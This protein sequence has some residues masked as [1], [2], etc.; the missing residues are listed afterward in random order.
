[1]SCER[2]VMGC[3]T[4]IAA[5]LLSFSA[6][7]AADF[8]WTGGAGNNLY[9]DKKN[10]SITNGSSTRD[11]PSWTEN[12]YIDT[13]L[14]GHD[15]TIILNTSDCCADILETRGAYK[16]TFVSDANNYTLKPYRLNLKA[17]DNEF[18]VP[19]SLYA[20]SDRTWP[21]YANATFNKDVTLPD[22]M[23]IDNATTSGNLKNAVHFYGKL[24]VKSGKVLGLCRAPFTNYAEV[25]FHGPLI[26]DEL[27]FGLG[28]KSGYAYFY[29]QDNQIGKL[30]WCYSKFICCD[31]NVYPS[32]LAVSWPSS[33]V[34]PATNPKVDQF[35]WEASPSYNAL[36]LNGHDQKA[37]MVS[38][39][40]ATR[41]PWITSESPAVLTLDGSG[42]AVATVNIGGKA[43][44]VVDSPDLVQEFMNSQSTTLGTLAVNQGVLRITGESLFSAVPEVSVGSGATFE[45]ASTS[46][47]AMAGLTNVTVAAGGTFKV[48]AGVVS[49]FGTKLSISLAEGAFV[50]TDADVTITDGLWV[51]GALI[52]SGSYAS[53]AWKKGTGTVTVNAPNVEA[54]YVWTGLGG[55]GRMSTPMN[56]QGGVK[57][58]FSST[59]A[60]YVFPLAGTQS[61]PLQIRVDEAIS[62]KSVNFTSPARGFVEL[63]GENGGALH[64]VN[65]GIFVTNAAN[66]AVLVRVS[67]PVA[68]SDALMV[69]VGPGERSSVAPS[70]GFE[71]LSALNTVGYADLTKDGYGSLLIQGENNVILGNVHNHQGALTMKGGNPVG[72]GTSYSVINYPNAND[73]ATTLDIVNATIDRNINTR[74]PGDSCGATIRVSGRSTIKGSVHNNAGGVTSSG[75]L[76]IHINAAMD[77][78]E[79][80]LC[81]VVGEVYADNNGFFILSGSGG[82][83]RCQKE[84]LCVRPYCDVASGSLLLELGARACGMVGSSYGWF[85]KIPVRL[86]A[87][88]CIYRDAQGD[89]CYMCYSEYA[90]IDLNGHRLTLNNFGCNQASYD[91]GGCYIK[92][93]VDSKLTITGDIV[94]DIGVHILENASLVRSGTG[95]T[96]IADAC[97]STGSLSV[98]GGTVRFT[99]SGSWTTVSDV[100]VG[101]AAG[102]A[103]LS[104]ANSRAFDGTTSINLK[105]NGRI[106]LDEG[107]TARVGELL[108]DGVS[109]KMGFWGSS[110]SGAPLQNNQCFSG[111][112]RLLVGSVSLSIII[113]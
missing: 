13:D 70:Y 3:A 93:G 91:A 63:V 25:H 7:A 89:Q 104:L 23:V 69:R 101:G 58:V 107:V 52:A 5:F 45:L 67:A 4:V 20:V 16:V 53:A 24:T 113:R 78:E 44:V 56:W 21:I 55:D 59:L 38:Y 71:F 36:D 29:S 81:T 112:G 61:A 74:N 92:G 98:T 94:D 111:K 65:G 99:E 73:T 34:N 15:V 47:A 51:N 12:G 37:P 109:Q 6:F 40:H 88:D 76:R 60:T 97:R 41:R 84:L 108:I 1:M 87:D 66:Q 18:N 42:T 82:T 50:E 26:C 49:P 106:E 11:G 103:K 72:G 95:V 96:T 35:Y 19:I 39:E 75:H 64:I 22:N 57:P 102:E 80:T 83:L 54:T 10:W 8:T 28:Y 46:A 110:E 43:S 90:G 77:Q 85:M 17:K 9:C 31:E 14:I 79:S 32:T 33:L 105:E 30:G 27:R 68:F 100:T 86:N 62:C 48:G 2:Q